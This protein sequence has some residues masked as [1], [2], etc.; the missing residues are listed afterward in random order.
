MPGI[1]NSLITT[2]NL[3]VASIDSASELLQQTATEIAF[4]MALRSLSERWSKGFGCRQPTGYL[5]RSCR[6]SVLI[7]NRILSFASYHIYA[8]PRRKKYMQRKKACQVFRN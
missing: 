7:E 8:C 6:Y 4:P 3:C 1:L 5:M 2:S